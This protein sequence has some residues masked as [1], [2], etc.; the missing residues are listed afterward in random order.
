MILPMHH[1]FAED[2]PV[3]VAAGDSL[4]AGYGLAAGEKNFAELVAEANGY[5]LIHCAE[6]GMM[7]SDV[8]EQ[9]ALLE[10]TTDL[11]NIDVITITCGLHDLMAPLY[12]QMADICN[13]N[14][15][16][17]GKI[18][19]EEIDAIMADSA[20]SRRQM[21][22]IAAGKVLAG[23]AGHGILPYEQSEAFK[24][25]LSRY[26]QKHITL[27]NIIHQMSPNAK[28]IMI[29]LYHPCGHFEGD[30]VGL[31]AGM[32]AAVM[33]MN[34]YI[35][36]CGSSM[37]RYQTAD[38]YA[39]F[40]ASEEDLLNTSIEFLTA[41]PNAAGHVVIAERVNALIHAESDTVYSDRPSIEK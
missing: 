1:T 38:I 4:T 31:N 18:S 35:R 13:A 22:L 26:M 17:S 37:G 10:L 24:H 21:L 28:I 5:R 33:K 7:A 23:D 20:D 19:P 14:L 29:T 16:R 30:F 12:Q 41:Y 8:I 15:P 9:F 27:M 2:R 11:E 25:A 39:A 36:Q 40:S 6:N 34:A 32:D 3:Y